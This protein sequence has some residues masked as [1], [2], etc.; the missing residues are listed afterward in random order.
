VGGEQRT[1]KNNLQARLDLSIR[2][3]TTIQRR[4]IDSSDPVPTITGSST[5]SAG[6]N[7]GTA[8]SLTTNGALTVQLRPTI[9]YLLNSRLNL[10]FYFTQTI[11]Q[12]RVSNAFRNS[13]TEGGI[14]LRYSLQ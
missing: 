3:N 5:P 1:L 4:I 7:L 9:D 14:Q 10:Q 6:G 13:T 8:T 11:T 12:P 2:D